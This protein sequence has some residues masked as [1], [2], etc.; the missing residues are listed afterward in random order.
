MFLQSVAVISRRDI[1][2]V[3]KAKIQHVASGIN[4]GHGEGVTKEKGEGH[5][6]TV[7]ANRLGKGSRSVNT[8]V[9][10]ESAVE[11]S[12]ISF[13]NS[14]LVRDFEHLT[15][16]SVA[17]VQ[18]LGVGLSSQVTGLGKHGDGSGAERASLTG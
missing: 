5:G 6:G 3:L 16:G 4:V 15:H 17:E 13:V 2:S 11:S 8:I 18:R 14:N 7:E 12:A 10:V 1:N 9:L